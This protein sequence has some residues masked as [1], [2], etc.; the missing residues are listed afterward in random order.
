MDF[1]TLAK[2]RYSVRKFD[3]RPVEESLLNQILEAGRVAPTARNEQNQRVYV[4]KSRE[5]LEKAKECSPC[6]F[7]APV[8]LMVCG[9]LTKPA[10]A[11][12]N[13]KCF[14]EMNASIVTTHMMLEAADLGLGSTWVCRFDPEKAKEVFDLPAEIEPYCL[15]PLGYAAADAAPSPMHANKKPASETIFY[16]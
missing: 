16:K 8:V 9:D 7:D 14:A 5:A 11:P 12:A 2:E 4:L 3:S 15:L 6:T 10:D 1:L 13:A